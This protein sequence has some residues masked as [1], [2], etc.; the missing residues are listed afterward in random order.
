MWNQLQTDAYEGMLAETVAMK[1][2]N[3]DTIHAYLSR[4]PWGRGR[5]RGLS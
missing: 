2:H 4:P 3:G 5:F 1:G